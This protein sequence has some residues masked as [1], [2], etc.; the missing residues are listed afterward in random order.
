SAY[1]YQRKI[2]LSEKI[3]VG[4]N[5]FQVSNEESIPIFRVNDKIREDQIEKLK[6]LKQKRDKNNVKNSLDKVKEKAINAEN[7]MPSVIDAVENY[8]TL[9]EISNVLREVFGEQK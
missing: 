7:I 2:E 9:G 6:A 5:K 1:E 3:I 4:V 8:C